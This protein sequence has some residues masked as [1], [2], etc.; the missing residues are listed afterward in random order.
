MIAKNY[1]ASVEPF[2]LFIRMIFDFIHTHR[3]LKAFLLGGKTSWV[4]EFHQ[5]Y[6]QTFHLQLPLYYQPF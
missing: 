3:H 4:M 6:Y 1:K 2:N 5:R